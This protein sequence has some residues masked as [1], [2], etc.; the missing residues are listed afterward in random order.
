MLKR[1]TKQVREPVN[2]ISAVKCAGTLSGKKKKQTTKLPL[3]FPLL[4]PKMRLN[5][6]IILSKAKRLQ[7]PNS[8]CPGRKA[9]NV[10]G[11]RACRELF[12]VNIFKLWN[13]EACEFN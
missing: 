7:S 5:C 6:V 8:L 12:T 11:V 2:H 13:P 4:N 10:A 1:P 3:G 9:N